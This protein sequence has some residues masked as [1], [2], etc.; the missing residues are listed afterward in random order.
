MPPRK[1]VDKKNAQ[2]CRKYREK[3]K[4]K[5]RKN[6]RER[7]VRQRMRM[8][9]VN[10]IKYKA[11]QE[12][13]R[14]RK[15]LERSRK[16]KAANEEE[17][18]DPN[19]DIHTG[20]LDTSF[21]HKAIKNRSLSKAQQALPKSPRKRNEIIGSLVN[22]FH[23]RVAFAPK[24]AGRK[25]ID[26]TEEERK[27]LIEFLDRPDM[28]YTT[29]GRRDNVYIGKENGEK[30]YVQKRYLLWPLKDIVETANNNPLNIGMMDTFE[31]H[32]GKKIS[33]SQ[34]YNF[35]RSHKEYVYNKNIPLSSC[36]C[37][38][39][40]N[41]CLLV[42]GIN[43]MIKDKDLILPSN[44]HDLVEKFC[45]N[46]ESK[47]CIFST[48]PNCAES[49]LSTEALFPDDGISSE[50]NSS[51]DGSGDGCISYFEWQRGRSNKVAK[52]KIQNGK[53][54][55]LDLLKERLRTLKEH[56]YTKRAQVGSLEE[57]KNSLSVEDA[58]IQV[59]YSENYENVQ[60]GEVQSAYFGHTSFS[61]FTAC[62]YFRSTTSGEIEKECIT[63]TSEASDHSRIAAMTC[64]D[65]V[66]DHIQQ[67]FPDNSFENIHIWS[68]GCAS[69]FRSRYVFMLLTYFKKD[70]NI[71]WHYNE[72]HHGKG[73]MDGIGGSLKNIV[74][75]AVK[76]G[77]VVIST[78]EE[79]ALYPDK[80][81][82]GISSLYLPE[83][84][85]IDEPEMVQSAPAIQ[86]TLKIH[87]VERRF[88]KA[89][90]CQLRF[91]TLTQEIAP[92]YTHWYRRE[93][94]AQVCGHEDGNSDDNTCSHCHTKYA[95]DGSDWLQCPLCT[96]WF[97]EV[98]FYL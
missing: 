15:R 5:Y 53:S 49:G 23:L 48:C 29:P 87:K 83:S 22:K 70:K 60:Q 2:Y 20:E 69:Q 80:A 55:A 54:N 79:F 94:D 38:I 86:G 35:I 64:I 93:T 65:K 51:D 95:D 44:P 24:K 34:L 67:K 30:Q 85:V 78:P 74:F 84:D 92:F 63:V 3:N 66:I 14:I 16:R 98:C 58:L 31:D 46:T 11:K 77:K 26:L 43:K 57:I 39:C 72:R 96:Q 25:R 47:E 9:L 89:G 52:V 4:E 97:H 36:L 6:D 19:I 13:D 56:I 21:T 10:P 32:F 61:I 75:R 71:T 41:I 7:K 90:I 82:A 81:I 18:Q 17:E 42:N 40:E 45:C 27:W 1:F 76:S 59:D 8:K 28:T 91:H 62:C 33:F 88:N 73:P 37:E 50:E 68:D 12:Q